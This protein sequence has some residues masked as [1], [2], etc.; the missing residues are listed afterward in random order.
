MALTAAWA[1]HPCHRAWSH[2]VLPA[3]FGLWEREVPGWLWSSPPPPA[4]SAPTQPV[5]DNP[6]GS[7][8]AFMLC[9]IFGTY[10]FK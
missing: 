9:H 1:K 4:S 2:P 8:T 5:Q 10:G 3:T 6:S 7:L